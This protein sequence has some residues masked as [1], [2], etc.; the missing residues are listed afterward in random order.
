MIERLK[1]SLNEFSAYVEDEYYTNAEFNKKF[2]EGY[3][4]SISFDEFV[5]EFN[6]WL[7]KLDIKSTDDGMMR[8][9]YCGNKYR[10]KE[11][12]LLC[13]ECREMF[14]HAFY[15]EL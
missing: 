11:E 14:G 3:P 12:D 10:T 7:D 1:K 15:S 13:L 5:N 8:C 2:N 9:K 6:N 4:L